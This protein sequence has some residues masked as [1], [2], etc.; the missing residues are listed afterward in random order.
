M[1]L[2]VDGLSMAAYSPTGRHALLVYPDV[3]VTGIALTIH[4]RSL[5]S[6]F[7]KTMS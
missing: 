6:A 2:P 4:V 3:T 1:E 5:C 7:R